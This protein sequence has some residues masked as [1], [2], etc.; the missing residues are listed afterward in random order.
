MYCRELNK[1]I[2]DYLVPGK[3]DLNSEYHAKYY[4]N[5][6]L[7][8]GEEEIV[9]RSSED[10]NTEVCINYRYLY[11]QW[12]EDDIFKIGSFEKVAQLPKRYRYSK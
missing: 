5:E 10:P 3:Q 11:M 9:T 12:D 6:Y 1:I 4:I 7:E 2:Q 8:T